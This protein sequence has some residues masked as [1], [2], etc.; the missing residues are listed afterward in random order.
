[1]AQKKTGHQTHHLEIT[2]AISKSSGKVLEHPAFEAW[3]KASTLSPGDLILLNNSFVFRS[4]VGTRK[5]ERFLGIPVGKDGELSA[6]PI[7]CEGLR[8]NSDFKIISTKSKNQPMCQAL[9]DAVRGELKQLGELV[10]LLVGSVEDTVVLEETLD[11]KLYDT[12]VLDPCMKS[13]VEL[14]DHKIR[15]RE[16]GNED[17]VWEAVKV[18]IGDTRNFDAVEE[19]RQKVGTALDSL[20]D[21]TYAVLKLPA[22]SGV[23]DT[24]VLD[25]ITAV[26]IDEKR[27]Y[28]TAVKKCRGDYG[29]DPEAYNDVLRIAY[30]FATDAIGFLRLLTSICDMKPIVLWCT[31]GQ[32]FRLS[33]TFK[34]LPWTRSRNKPSLSNYERIIGDARN[35]AFH[36]LFPFSKPIDVILPGGSLADLRLRIFSE[37]AKRREN[38]LTFQDKGMVELL[39]E[40]TITREHSVPSGFWA[41]NLE[42]MNAT[43]NVFEAIGQALNLLVDFVNSSS[44][45]E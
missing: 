37:Y 4:G 10:F 35:K 39:K 42:V 13:D 16:P 31:V 38:D 11:D 33:E 18:A 20:G 28:E 30:N 36:R 32:Q 24:S 2:S 29:V 40:F 14:K 6:Q 23:S 1:M 17:R 25:S 3:K 12:V 15:V 22:A 9:G 44:L 7:V 43:I 26:L 45:G 27:N 5:S 41:R 8:F 21:R 19:L 34:S